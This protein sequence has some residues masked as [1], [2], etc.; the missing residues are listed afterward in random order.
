MSV[1]SFIDVNFDYLDK[2]GAPDFFTVKALFSSLQLTY[3]L[4][5]GHLRRSCS[6]T[7]FHP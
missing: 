3:N 5:G 2:E 7:S 6:P 4:R 1:C